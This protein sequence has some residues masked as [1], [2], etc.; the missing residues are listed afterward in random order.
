[1]AIT[2]HQSIKEVT[3]YI[4]AA[5]RKLRAASALNNVTWIRS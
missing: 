5:S 4:S 2:G 1:M 3:R